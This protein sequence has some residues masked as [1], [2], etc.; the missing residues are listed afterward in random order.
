MEPAWL[1]GEERRARYRILAPLVGTQRKP[2]SEA[3]Q[4]IR[5]Q[6]QPVL[7]CF[8]SVCVFEVAQTKART[9]PSLPHV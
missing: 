1:K 8:R 6:N 2:D 4:D 5:T 3:N 9:F 7:V